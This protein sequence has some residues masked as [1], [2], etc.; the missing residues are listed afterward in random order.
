[1]TRLR[2]ELSQA[3]SG[4]SSPEFWC[5][6]FLYMRYCFSISLK[7]LLATCHFISQLGRVGGIRY[8]SCVSLS[9]SSLTKSCVVPTLSPSVCIQSTIWSAEQEIGTDNSPMLASMDKLSL[10]PPFTCVR[11]VKSIIATFCSRNEIVVK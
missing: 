11:K 2:P 8:R 7:C 6:F 3:A 1:M 10:F 4:V 5:F 9:R